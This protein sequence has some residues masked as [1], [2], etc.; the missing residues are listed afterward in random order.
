[1]SIEHNAEA[2]VGHVED[3]EEATAFESRPWGGQQR[4]IPLAHRFARPADA[5]APEPVVVEPIRP[6][7]EVRRQRIS[8]EAP[9]VAAGSIEPAPMLVLSA[10]PVAATDV[11]TEPVAPIAP[12]YLESVAPPAIAAYSVKH[13]CAYGPFMIPHLPKIAQVYTETDSTVAVRRKPLGMRAMIAAPV[14]AVLGVVAILII[15]L[16]GPAPSTK[17]VAGAALA[18]DS[19]PAI[20]KMSIEAPAPAPALA[21]AEEAPPADAIVETE[22]EIETEPQ[23]AAQPVAKTKRSSRKVKRG[24]HRPRRIVAVDTSTPLG[25]LRPGRM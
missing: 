8:R 16:A 1:M 18:V 10:P 2:T 24:S 21:V 9:R 7:R 6:R 20:V 11:I 13:G 5:A 23:I 4:L 19:E 17:Q 15:Y 3:D 14:G 12:A 22:I 25:N